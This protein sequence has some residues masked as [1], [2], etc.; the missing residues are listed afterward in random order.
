MYFRNLA[1]LL[2][3]TTTTALAEPSTQTATGVFD[4]CKMAI[5]EEDT[6][7]LEKIVKTIREWGGIADPAIAMGASFCLELAVQKLGNSDASET[8][9]AIPEPV[10]PILS[11]YRQKADASGTDLSALVEEIAGNTEFNPEPGDLRDALEMALLAYAKPLP[12]VNAEANRTAYA[13][14]ERINPESAI[15]GAKVKQYTDAIHATGKRVLGSLKKTTEAFDGS[16][17]SRHPSSPRY[18]DTRSYV[19]LYLIDDGKGRKSLNLFLN[20]TARDGWLFVESAEVNVDG[21][22]RRLPTTRWFRDN[23]T[24]I[25][26]WAEYGG[27][28]MISVAEEIANSTRTVVRF[29]GQQFFDDLVVSGNDKKVMRDMLAVW[30]YLEDAR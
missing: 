16:S 21:N 17:W 10:D 6:S 30:R 22:S 12:A 29:N 27:S 28:A 15:Y 5:V 11:A 20:Y 1:G 25:W 4:D 7:A 14:L 24:E 19:T 9:E 2:F 8:V 23:D 26:E 13:A 3:L 18:Q